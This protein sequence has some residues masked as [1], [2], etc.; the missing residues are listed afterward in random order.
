MTGASLTSGIVTVS[1]GV[2]DVEAMATAFSVGNHRLRL[3]DVT[4]AAVLLEG[5]NANAPGASWQTAG[6]LRGR[7]TL[8]V[9]TELR[10]DH[11]TQTAATAGLGIPATAGTPEIYAQLWLR[12]VAAS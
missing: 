12:W 3:Y 5:L 7:I 10:L 2:Y 6:L 1:A 8:A 11:F 4:G 9:E